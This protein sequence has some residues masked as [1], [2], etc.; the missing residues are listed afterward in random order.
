MDPIQITEE[1]LNAKVLEWERK[2]GRKATQG[3]VDDIYQQMLSDNSGQTDAEKKAE[4]ARKKQPLTENN[5]SAYIKQL[6]SGT[7]ATTA[8]TEQPAIPRA[9]VGDVKNI[10]DPVTQKP[11]EGVMQSQRRGS[12]AGSYNYSGMNLV[13]ENNRIV[14]QTITDNSGG[15]AANLLFQQMKA[16]N[17][18]PQFLQALKSSNHYQSKSPSNLAVS[19]KGMTDTD[20]AAIDSFINSAN[21][22][23]YTPKGYLKQMEIS[24]SSFSV[25]SSGG[26][27]SSAAYPNR[28]D[29]VRTLRDE[30]FRVLGRPM[31][32]QEIK[33]A[34][35]FVNHAYIS[36]GAAG[37][38]QA[39]SLQSAA[40]VAVS[41]TAGEEAAVYGLGTALDRIFKR[42]GSI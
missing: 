41:K 25:V 29:T 13:D 24:P 18:L 12:M 17:K 15:A 19:G 6:T 10:I 39:P 7:A 26:S 33:A 32:P 3:D 11:L 42:G 35:G 8:V 1:E 9:I 23:R 37:G 38:E 21:L 16:D 36:A 5:R 4:E 34:V 28:M 40:E 20:Y 22:A 14:N 2:K 27:G 31:T 30:S